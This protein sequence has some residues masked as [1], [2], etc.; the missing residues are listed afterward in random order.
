MNNLAKI[1]HFLKKNVRYSLLILFLILIF[2]YFFYFKKNKEGLE[3]AIITTEDEDALINNFN[4]DIK[5]VIRTK[6]TDTNSDTIKNYVNSIYNFIVESSAPEDKR[7]E[8]DNVR[9]VDYDKKVE[10]IIDTL[11]DGQYD[12]NIIDNWEDVYIYFL[13]NYIS[14][15]YKSYP[16][17]YTDENENKDKSF[18]SGGSIFLSNHFKETFKLYISF[19]LLTVSLLYYILY[20]NSRKNELEI[21]KIVDT[22][23]QVNTEKIDE[24]TDKIE[25]IGKLI[26]LL[27]LTDFSTDD[28]ER[29]ENIGGFFQLLLL[30]AFIDISDD[31]RQDSDTIDYKEKIKYSAINNDYRLMNYILDNNILKDSNKSSIFNTIVENNLKNCDNLINIKKGG[32][33]TEII[34]DFTKVENDKLLILEPLKDIME[35]INT[36]QPTISDDYVKKMIGSDQYVKEENKEGEGGEE[37]ATQ[38][39]IAQTK[40]NNQKLIEIS[41][42]GTSDPKDPEDFRGR[43][44]FDNRL[45]LE[46]SKETSEQIED[47]LDITPPEGETQDRNASDFEAIGKEIICAFID[48]FNKMIDTAGDDLDKKMN[49]LAESYWIFNKSLY[50]WYNEDSEA[51]DWASGRRVLPNPKDGIPAVK[52]MFQGDET[53]SE[54]HIDMLIKINMLERYGYIIEALA[55]DYGNSTNLGYVF[56]SGEEGNINFRA[57][58]K[59]RDDAKYMPINKIKSS[60]CVS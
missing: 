34:S 15:F 33:I 26:G 1:T 16:Y 8:A 38:E 58:K 28:G 6:L 43:E 52:K 25:N 41:V 19:R 37:T 39:Q 23:G 44:G 59:I 45:M 49:I 36:D 3:I 18:Y 27:G 35:E 48:H 22:Q 7:G 46:I 53:L 51:N 47:I 54:K 10:D 60:Y 56:G 17:M 24:N 2:V 13:K 50:D 12:N 32:V 21:I 31:P 9:D 20:I 11:I 4:N 29:R 57:F 30:W 14:E 42:Q 5:E 40:S 55:S